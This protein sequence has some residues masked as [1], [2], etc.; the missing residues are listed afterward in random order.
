MQQ[1]DAPPGQ[2]TA[3]GLQQAF[4]S[5]AEASIAANGGVATEALKSE[6]AMR[7]LT[8]ATD[9]AGRTIVQ[10][11]S[12]GSQAVGGLAQSLAQ[13]NQAVQE[14]LGWLDRL[15][16]RNAEVKSTLVT[17]GQGF[18]ADAKGNRIVA[19]GDLTTLTGI[20]NFL[21]QAGLDEDKAKEVATEFSDGKGNI[22]YF[23]NP[24]QKKYGGDFSTISDALLKAAERTTFGL[25]SSGGQAIGRTVNVKIDTG[26]GTET[27]ATDE[28]GAK[29]VV[30]AL[31]AA[32]RRAGR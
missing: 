3:Q 9:A 24:G 19:G 13:A 6:A 8:V 26:S 12:S 32:A 21:K 28:A 7:G 25:G 14:H 2:A 15:E 23:S 1:G 27:V 18:A 17:D 29:A 30:K 11:M 20:T 5:Y 10:A 4:K 22:P 16:K 31:G